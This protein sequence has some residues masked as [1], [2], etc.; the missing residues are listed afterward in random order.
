MGNREICVG[1]G[2]IF[3]GALG[4]APSAG[5]ARLERIDLTMRDPPEQ[6]LENLYRVFRDQTGVQTGT[7]SDSDTPFLFGVEQ[8]DTHLPWE[9]V[10]F[11]SRTQPAGL[12]TFSVVA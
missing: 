10:P 11:C 9:E 12:E 3:S 7:S 2:N 1:F 5:S 4:A 6:I 8:T